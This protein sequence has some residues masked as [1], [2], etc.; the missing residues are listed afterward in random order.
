[1]FLNLLISSFLW[2]LSLMDLLLDH[3][4]KVHLHWIG[5]FKVFK[6]IFLGSFFCFG[7][8]WMKKYC[9]IE[10]ACFLWCLS[11]FNYPWQDE[12]HAILILFHVWELLLFVVVVLLSV[13]LNVDF[14]HKCCYFVILLLLFVNVVERFCSWVLVKCCEEL[15]FLNVNVIENKGRGAKTQRW[16]AKNW[17]AM[18]NSLLTLSY[19][20]IFGPN[21]L[22]YIFLYK[23]TFFLRFNVCKH[24]P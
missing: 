14:I 4:W 23:S 6:H 15:L 12:L 16:W 10:I 3:G 5:K 9:K 2:S 22:H 21:T 11:H 17:W 24:F 1:M 20:P 8:N 18:M 7:N 13:L 19:L